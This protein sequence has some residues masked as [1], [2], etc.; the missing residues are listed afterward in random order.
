[1]YFQITQELVD[2]THFQREYPTIIATCN[3]PNMRKMVVDKQAVCG[4]QS[5]GEPL[6]PPSRWLVAAT[7]RLI[8][9]SP[10]RISLTR[11]AI[12]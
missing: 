2:V 4:A 10:S 9:F 11:L 3:A 7:S 12:S 5:L 1:M 6:P 8:V